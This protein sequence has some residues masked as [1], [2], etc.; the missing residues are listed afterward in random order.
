MIC[1][2]IAN[3]IIKLAN[4]NSFVSRHKTKHPQQNIF[5]KPYISPDT[6]I[7][8]RASLNLNFP[9]G[10]MQCYCDIVTAAAV[11]RIEFKED[12]SVDIGIASINFTSEVVAVDLGIS[13]GCIVPNKYR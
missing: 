4:I 9:N 7:D 2:N 13:S 10:M 12:D 11:F 3:K 8:H 6:V 1:N 5:K